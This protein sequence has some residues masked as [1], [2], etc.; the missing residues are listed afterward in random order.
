MPF[1]IQSLYGNNDA[2]THVTWNV[3]R[4]RKKRCSCAG[5]SKLFINMSQKCTPFKNFTTQINNT[6]T[7]N[8]KGLDFIIQMFKSLE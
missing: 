1:L 5:N 7:D 2:C 3:K 8:T 4:T 6:Q